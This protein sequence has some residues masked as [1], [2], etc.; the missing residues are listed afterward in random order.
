MVSCTNCKQPLPGQALFCPHC[1]QS[2][3]VSTRPW[4][5]VFKELLKDMF[6]FDGR[7][8]GSWPLILPDSPT[9]SPDHKIELASHIGP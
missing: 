3:K 6:D 2:I 5:E 8:L 1:G 9:T 7:V 4:L